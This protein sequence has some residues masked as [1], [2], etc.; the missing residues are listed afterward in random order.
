MAPQ[1]RDLRR[2]ETLDEVRFTPHQPGESPLRAFLDRHQNLVP[3]GPT[4]PVIREGL[5]PVGP[6]G[7]LARVAERARAV[8]PLPRA[9][10][11]PAG[12]DRQERELGQE[13]GERVLRPN[14]DGV[15]V[16]RADLLD[17][18]QVAAQRRLAAPHAVEDRNHIRSREQAAVVEADLPAE[19]EDPGSIVG[20]V[21]GN[22]QLGLGPA[23]RPEPD[24]A[25]VDV[26]H[27]RDGPAA[28]ACVLELR[29]LGR[30]QEWV[31]IA[32]R[33]RDD[34]AQP[35]GRVGATGHR[36]ESGRRQR[37][38]RDEAPWSRGQGEPRGRAEH[39]TGLGPLSTRAP[40]TSANTSTRC[41]E[42]GPQRLPRT[43]GHLC[44]RA[45]RF[46]SPSPKR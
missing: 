46:S 3:R 21:P 1:L 7:S 40:P 5:E 23:V 9:R 35:A 17:Q 2:G 39:A 25:L 36:H 6:A 26:E 16:G 4:P 32:D 45:T 11:A 14:T 10:H 33:L 29:L 15:L 41:C 18:A 42:L 44:A 31:E 12:R 13:Q 43:R 34:G 27:E 20:V 30:A 19:L 24:E 37:D 8:G 28:R 22:G 38:E